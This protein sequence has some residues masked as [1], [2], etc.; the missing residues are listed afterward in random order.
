[1]VSGS[2]NRLKIGLTNMFKTPSTMAKII[3]DE[4]PSKC[5]P[6]KI[7]VK[8]YATIAVISNLIIKFISLFFN[9]YGICGAKAIPFQEKKMRKNPLFKEYS[10]HN[11]LY[12]I[13][14]IVTNE[15]AT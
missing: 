10:I 13:L 4:N 7:L 9:V 1:M 12:L 3:A 2:P 5:T 8:R 14:I 11:N 6:G 15:V